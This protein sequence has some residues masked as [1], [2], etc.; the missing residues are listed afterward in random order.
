MHKKKARSAAAASRNGRGRLGARKVARATT[1]LLMGLRRV[2]FEVVDG[3]GFGH[4]EGYP[5][6]RAMLKRDKEL[7]A[8]VHRLVVEFVSSLE[9][10][11]ERELSDER[12]MV[13]PLTP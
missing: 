7:L 12:H 8:E 5:V 10:A 4:S 11:L 3:T 13:A 1:S 9:L 6:L 2:A